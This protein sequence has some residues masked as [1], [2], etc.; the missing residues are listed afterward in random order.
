MVI[1]SG[2]KCVPA[3]KGAVGLVGLVDVIPC[4][5]S[6]FPLLRFGGA[7]IL[8]CAGSTPAILGHLFLVIS[9]WINSYIA[10]E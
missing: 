5:E 10:T 3:R 2:A 7:G 4:D 6:H 1:A 9:A 8:I